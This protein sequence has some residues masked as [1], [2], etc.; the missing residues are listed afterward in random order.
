[1]LP[2]SLLQQLERA[3]QKLATGR[4]DRSDAARQRILEEVEVALRELDQALREASAKCRHILNWADAAQDM[5]FV[6]GRDWRVEY[7]NPAGAAQF[8][9]RPED[10]IGR[11]HAELFPPEIVS[12]QRPHLEKV[13]QTEQSLYTEELCRFPSGDRFLSTWLVPLRNDAGDI[14]AIQGVSRDITERR[15]ME[16]DLARRTRQLEAVSRS[17]RHINALLEVP[18][19]LRCLVTGALEVTEASGGMA[20]LMVEGRMVFTEYDRQ[21]ARSPLNLQCGRGEGVAGW[22]LDS[23]LP[24]SCQ[25]ATRDAHVDPAFQRQLGFR[26]LVNV[27][28]LSAGGQLLGCLEVHD[29]CSGGAFDERD[30]AVLE[31]LAA[32]AAIALENARVVALHEQA[33]AALRESSYRF[34]RLFQAN[35][36]AMTLT[37]RDEGRILDANESFL[38]LTG[39]SRA[40]LIGRTTFELSLWADPAQRADMVAQ[41]G[42][43]GVVHNLET[44]LRNKSGQLLEILF[45]SELIHWGQVPCILSI[46]T[47]ITK[48][49][50]LEA[51]MWQIQK[52][53]SIGTLAGG[54]AH[55]FN[56]LLTVIQGHAG[57]LL[58]D[59]SLPPKALTSLRLVND[60]AIRAANLTRQLLAF[61]GRQPMRPRA[62]DLNDI[63]HHAVKMLRRTIRE[64]I[65]F[66]CQLAPDLPQVTGDAAM[67]EQVLVNLAINARDAMLHGGRL[68]L[69]TRRHDVSPAETETQP[70]ARAGSFVCLEVQDT[71]GG[72]APETLPR[73]FD[74]FFTTKEFGQGSG[75]GLAAVHGIVE[76]HHGWIEVSSD[77]GRGTRFCVFLP[78]VA[79]LPEPTPLPSGPPERGR[80]E[81]ILL[82]EDN[83]EVRLLNQQI[84]EDQG[85]QVWAAPTGVAAESVWSEHQGAFDLLLTDLVMPE[86]VS[87]RQLAERL[88]AQSSRL[89]VMLTSG[90][91]PETT[92]EDFSRLSWLR[93]L[94]KPYTPEFLVAEVRA[95]LDAKPS[96]S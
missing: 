53:E 28:I 1:M 25:D 54:V 43:S 44:R 77:A 47:D 12:R 45:S 56:N 73:I 6:I 85:Y 14:T 41:L 13:F 69:R 38:L 55:D 90:Y 79:Q 61:S 80:R 27:P 91:G 71:G 3:R 70:R 2:P 64:D 94:Q 10:V 82:V 23:R 11:A 92:G 29:P 87:G 46:S 15:R 84:L 40:E 89:R 72:I 20:G 30:V 51:R 50:R 22:V 18:G 39:Y 8:Q 16:Q 75:L 32:S 36:L 33:E 60:A 93:F 63:V 67:L 81:K 88:R 62:V 59:A 57:L 48:R 31:G 37:T 21:G 74:P 5:V 83:E 9:R 7:V 24:Y 86:G 58:N 19:I 52:M 78:V 68:H 34:Q 35:P 42:R 76:Q 49:K 26:Q 66:E 95:C 4:A 65:H 17:A 96:L